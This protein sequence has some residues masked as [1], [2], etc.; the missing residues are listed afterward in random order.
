MATEKKKL[1]FNPVSGQF[2]TIVD[3]ADLAETA[4]LAAYQLLSEK[5]QANGYVPLDGGSKVPVIHLPNSVMQYQ[6][7]YDAST[8]LPLLV[9][10]TGNAGDVYEVVVAG[11]SDFG[12]GVISFNVGDW[13]VYNGS[14]WQKSINSNEVV[15]VNG[16]TGAV[17]LDTDDIAEGSNL[18][19]TDE[20]A[21]DAVGS[22]LTDSA[23]IDF[24]YN[25]GGNSISAIVI[26][27]SLTNQ[28]IA[29]G[30]DAQ[31]IGDGSVDNTEF[32]YLDGVTAPIQTQLDASA[33]RT[34]SNLTSPTAINQDLIFN[35]TTPFVKTA[36]TTGVNSQT[37]SVLTGAVTTTGSSGALT[38]GT[39]NSPSASGTI[40]LA[41]GTTAAS[42]AASGAVTI[43]SGNTTTGNASSGAVT[44]TTGTSFGTSVTGALTLSTGI[45]PGLA[46]SG[47]I[48]MNTGNV[49]TNTS[50]SSGIVAI[51]SGTSVAGATG[52]T[53][54]VSLASGNH[55]SASTASGTVTI[56]SGNQT[57]TAFSG[58]GGVTTVTTGN[59][60][61]ATATGTTGIT[62]ILSGNTAGSGGSSGAV[63]VRSGNATAAGGSSGS[64]TIQTG[65]I[66][67]GGTRGTIRLVDASLATASVGHVWTLTNTGTGAGQWQAGAAVKET[68]SVWCSSVQSILAGN[69]D[70]II[71]NQERY[72]AANLYN[73]ANG[74]FQLA[75]DGK[76]QLN[77]KMH[78]NMTPAGLYFHQLGVFK[79][80]TAYKVSGEYENNTTNTD[81]TTPHL[82]CQIE[83]LT[84][85]IWT[86]R[87][88]NTGY[89]VT[90]FNGI[91]YN[92][93][94]LTM[95]D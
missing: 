67:S 14:I 37:L 40:L 47:N 5:G 54:A 44:V 87:Y 21:Q 95:I 38:V 68:F 33:N 2:D 22:I 20:R 89:G 72:D 77:V 16:L 32:Q 45:S 79:N 88:V 30:L 91:A 41:S 83:G 36:D 80:G 19:F 18:Y 4:D 60:T 74:Q 71:C 93:I 59:I 26:D 12:A 43:R 56:T 6:G 15:S 25:D 11:S 35:K 81:Y 29:S 42:G 51:S 23:F 10:G 31:K 8:D 3:V 49:T 92:Y 70:I 1:I 13:V 24:S 28:K 61:N 85:D 75:R 53:G 52:N 84:T 82:N 69:N 78:V 7:Q 55:A 27:G 58:T 63:N 57:G 17:T 62:N 46:G 9:N 76:A 34:L 48:T 90:I 66:V 86:I 94:D 73:T 39:G 50:G 65:S 64:V